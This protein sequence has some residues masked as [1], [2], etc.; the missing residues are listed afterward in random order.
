V[1]AEHFLRRWQ[2][3]GLIDLTE[4]E[5]IRAWEATHRR[6]VVFWA[7]AGT[8]VLAVSLG[9]MAI[10][11]ANWEEIPA[12]LKLAVDLGLN[13]AAAVAVFVF[14]RRHRP[15]LTE[16][17]ALLLFAL[18][19]SGIALIGQVYQ[20]QSA[21]WRALVSWL[22]LCTPFLAL[23]AV[24]RLSG[25]LWGIAAGVTWFM[26]HEPIQSVLARVGVFERP[27]D[28]WTSAYM[29]PLLTYGLACLMI[30]VSV[31]R[32]LWRRTRSQAD[33]M[34]RL[35]FAGLI[36]AS[37]LAVTFGWSNSD[38]GP[39][40]PLAVGAIVT[41]AAALALAFG[42]LEFERPAALAVLLGSAAIWAAGLLLYRYQDLTSDLL[43]AT[44]FILYWSGIGALAARAGWRGWFGFAFTM[45]GLRL[46]VL[47]FQ[48]IGGLTAT[49]LGLIGGGVLCLALAAVGWRLTHRIGQAAEAAAR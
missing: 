14:W 3:A 13:A 19:L 33:L 17:S 22:V 45:I 20:L 49:G 27:S 28:Y 4:A 31:L 1:I 8:G 48:A 7:V 39:G 32:G 29:F 30:A 21:P 41:A 23:T 12:W 38:A 46:L 44:L 10:V 47:Y 35:S 18:V 43:R 34:L 6:P 40:G 16:I 37:T 24:S 9:I 15:W 25:V 36:M 11:S 42:H 5:R 26:A 2:N